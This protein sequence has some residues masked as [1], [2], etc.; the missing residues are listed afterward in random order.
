MPLEHPDW[1]VPNVGTCPLAW[2][3]LGM[4]FPS[5]FL[6][7]TLRPWRDCPV[8]SR[9]SANRDAMEFDFDCDSLLALL[10]QSQ[11]L[12]SSHWSSPAIHPRPSKLSVTH[13]GSIKNG[14]TPTSLSPRATGPSC[15][16][17]KN[18]YAKCARRLVR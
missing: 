7:R 15:S 4:A 18:F 2:Q 10:S 1:S 17:A 13:A 5:A 8:D 3:G 11:G 14:L 16:A 12:R 6:R 9:F